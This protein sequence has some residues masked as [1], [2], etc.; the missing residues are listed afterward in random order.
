MDV[1]GCVQDMDTVDVEFASK[2]L[3]LS[4]VS[5]S[6]CLIYPC[7]IEVIMLLCFVLFFLLSLTR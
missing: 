1:L 2:S 3:R 7:W 5:V 6:V 4:V